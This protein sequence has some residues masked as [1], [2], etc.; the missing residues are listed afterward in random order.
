MNQ[1]AEKGRPNPQLKLT[2]TNSNQ[3]KQNS[4]HRVYAQTSIL[5]R[6][7]VIIWALFASNSTWHVTVFERTFELLLGNNLTGLCVAI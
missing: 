1:K 4:S 5:T 2:Q 7:D 3:L 6:R